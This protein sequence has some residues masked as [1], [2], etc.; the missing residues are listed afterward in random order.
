[1]KNVLIQD[2]MED[3]I[4]KQTQLFSDF[5]TILNKQFLVVLINLCLV[6][7]CPTVSLG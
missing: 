1:M 6:L 5:P 2:Y 4:S 7:V 3:P